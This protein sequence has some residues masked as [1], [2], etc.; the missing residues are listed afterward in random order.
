ML[1]IR[2]SFMKPLL[3]MLVIGLSFGI[4]DEPVLAATRGIS[5]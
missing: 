4:W 2:G 5:L 1:I 3:V